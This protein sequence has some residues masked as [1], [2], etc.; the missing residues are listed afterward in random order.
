[1]RVGQDGRSKS[2]CTITPAL[3]SELGKAQQTLFVKGSGSRDM[4]FKRTTAIQLSHYSFGK[5]TIYG[6]HWI[7]FLS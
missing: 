5:I 3:M 7:V 2:S 4:L 1:M 6:L